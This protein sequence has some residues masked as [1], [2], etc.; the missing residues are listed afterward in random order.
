V[1]KTPGKDLRVQKTQWAIRKTFAAMICE[2]D[3]GQITIKACAPRMG[4]TSLR[5]IPPTGAS[6][7]SYDKKYTIIWYDVG[8]R[9][10]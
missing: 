7:R 10:D 9:S 8:V 3:Y 4:R 2:M 6:S 1:E 5:P